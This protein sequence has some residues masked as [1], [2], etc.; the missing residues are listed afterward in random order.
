MFNRLWIENNLE[1]QELWTA[2]Y[3]WAARESWTF[4]PFLLTSMR[5]Y[6]LA[7][8]ILFLLLRI[9]WTD[10]EQCHLGSHWN[11]L[12]QCTFAF[13]GG[14]RELTETSKQRR[15]M[16]FLWVPRCL[17]IYLLSQLVPGYGTSFIHCGTSVPPPGNN[18]NVIPTD[19]VVLHW[20][21]TA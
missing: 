8:Q 5:I 18:N 3:N 12:F 2:V 6:F 7:S 21:N 13:P 1:I 10:P 15:P 9:Y 14:W 4:L 19:S 17:P 11:H 20:Y 16:T